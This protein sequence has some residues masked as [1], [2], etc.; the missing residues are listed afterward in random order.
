MS[1][2][3]WEPDEVR[4]TP[5]TFTRVPRAAA[6]RASTGA[7]RHAGGR[8]G[9]WSEKIEQRKKPGAC[10]GACPDPCSVIK[11][12]H[13]VCLGEDAAEDDD[14]QPV[15]KKSNSE[16][17]DFQECFTVP[18]DFVMACTVPGCTKEAMT[19]TPPGDNEARGRHVPAT[20]PRKTFQVQFAAIPLGL[21]AEAVELG[22][23]NSLCRIAWMGENAGTCR[24][25]I[26]SV[27]SIS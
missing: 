2:H 9:R 24:C 14:S 3:A 23:S 26:S 18:F 10:P 20:R 25:G 17:F 7:A 5:A 16:H 1:C 12:V 21:V 4:R 11:L 22:K 13:C 27:A 15:Q 8:K 6:R 19:G